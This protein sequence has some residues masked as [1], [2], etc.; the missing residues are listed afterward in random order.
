M[1]V[2]YVE[3]LDASYQEGPLSEDEFTPHVIL[4]SGGVFVREDDKTVT[5]A[6][7]YCGPNGDWRH[8]SHIPKVNIIRQKIF[9]VPEK[10]RK[11]NAK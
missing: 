2:V 10:S 1:K 4:Y 11:S 8:V 9:N 5:L 7:D 6:T 3:W